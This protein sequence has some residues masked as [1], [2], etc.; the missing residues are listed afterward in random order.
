MTTLESILQQARQLSP[1]ERLQLI[2]RLAESDGDTHGETKTRR[3]W[4]E[5]AG[6]APNLMQGADAQVW[7]SQNRREADEERQR[8]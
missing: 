1:E 8:Q 7:V 6:I 2:S 4:R 5:I 3:H